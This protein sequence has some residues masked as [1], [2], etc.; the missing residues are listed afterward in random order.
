MLVALTG[1]ETVSIFKPDFNITQSFWSNRFRPSVF[2]GSK[3]GRPE[4]CRPHD[5]SVGDSFTTNYSLFQWSLVA[6]TQLTDNTSTSLVYKGSTL[7][8]CDVRALYMD[9][10]LQTRSAD[11]ATLITC[12]NVNG[13]ELL[14]KTSFSVGLLSGK[15]SPPLLGAIPNTPGLD[16]VNAKGRS[17]SVLL[18]RM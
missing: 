12:D 1:Y 17:R 5:F 2:L 13:F 3:R 14:A 9:A 15:Y 18:D 16:N 7:E 10:Q 6:V 8:T 11:L 4:L